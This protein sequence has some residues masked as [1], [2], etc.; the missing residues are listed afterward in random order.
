MPAEHRLTGLYGKHPAFGDFVSAGLPG[1]LTGLLAGWMQAVFGQWREDVGAGWQAAFDAAPPVRFWIGGE[2]TGGAALRGV[3]LPSQ[4]RSGRRFPLMLAQVAGAPPVHDPDQGFY[5]QAVTLV[6]GWR[7]AADFN[8]AAQDA[9]VHGLPEPAGVSV[10]S[11][12]F[13]A[14]NPGLGAV[15]LWPQLAG[16]DHAH[17][18]AGRSYW[19]ITALHDQGPAAV[20]AVQGWPDSG[21]LNWLLAG[22]QTSPHEM[23]P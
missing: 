12:G 19:W 11:S 15:G 18:A 1:D 8:P 4:D 23:T 5:D 6:A 20:V 10:Q 21:L 7:Q 13:W 3:W 9:V 2:L 16:N 14:A 17:A 22:G